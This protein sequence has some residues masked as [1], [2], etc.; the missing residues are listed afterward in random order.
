MNTF[1]ARFF[2]QNLIM[3]VG[4]SQT[5]DQLVAAFYW[6]RNSVP[7]FWFIYFVFTEEIFTKCSKVQLSLYLNSVFTNLYFILSIFQELWNELLAALP[8]HLC[9]YVPSQTEYKIAWWWW[10]FKIQ[11]KLFDKKIIISAI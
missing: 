1:A 3:S 5:L 2:F 11:Q 7:V 9:K 4:R 8:K 10:C 6:A